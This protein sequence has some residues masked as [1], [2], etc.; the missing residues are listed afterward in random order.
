[1]IGVIAESSGTRGGPRI[2]RAVQDSVGV[3][4][5]GST[6]RCFAL[7]R[8]W[9][10]RGNRRSRPCL[11]RQKDSV[12]TT[13]GICNPAANGK[14]PCILSYHGNRIPIYG[15]T[16]TFPAQAHGLLAREDSKE[17]AAYLGEE[18]GR[19]V[20]RIG[21]DLFAE[22]RSLLTVGQPAANANM[23]ALELHI[24]LLRN[25]ITGCGIPLVE[26]PPIPDGYQFVACLTHDVD[27]PSIRQH[28]W[29]HTMFGF[30]YRAI[31]GS[32]RR[33]LRGQISFRD[34]LTNWM[35]VLKL[36]F[37]HLG[38]AK[39]FWR[40]FDDRY[41]E[42]EKG[43]RATFFVIPFSNRAGSGSDGPAPVLRATR[44]RARDLAD[45]IRKLTSCRLR[46]WTARNRRVA[47][48]F[49]GAAR[50]SKRFDA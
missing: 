15:D 2:L 43:L 24:A 20:A 36:P 22:I 6:I 29:D 13:S 45:T 31:F 50:N 1:M 37:V 8:R 16:I 39:D 18:E 28:K 47:R 42:L 48:Q 14:H 38:L 34:L 49:Q 17:C 9:P 27:H 46:S 11:C 41:L 3:L 23:P 35:A 10:V 25:L 44:Y 19:V 32:L 40:E 5:Q 7:R 30:L 26:I 33:L 12:L 4:S 21:Y